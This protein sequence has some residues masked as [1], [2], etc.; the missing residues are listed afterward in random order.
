M[1]SM[2]S[3]SVL[4]LS[5]SAVAATLLAGSLALPAYAQ[6]A[7]IKVDP[8]HATKYLNGGIGSGEQQHMRAVAKDWPLKMIFSER[9]NDEFVANVDVRVMD[10]RDHV[11]LDLQKA[12]PM[13]YAMLPSGT[14]R[15]TASFNG[16]SETH[17]VKVKGNS[18]PD[19]YFH[20][21][22]SHQS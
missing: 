19:V 21:S 20:W 22:G 7:V 2:S 8:V 1:K 17:Q 12:G 5:L 10:A 4:R 16:V 9:K 6:D 13:T 18:T 14:Y 3:P 15:I 11:V